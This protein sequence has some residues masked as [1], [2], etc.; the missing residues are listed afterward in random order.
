MNIIKE[1]DSIIESFKTKV[2]P[3]PYIQNGILLHEALTFCAACVSSK[4]DLII[5]SGIAGGR[6]TE[7][8][9]KFFNIPIIGVD[10][11]S[12]YGIER[13]LSTRTRLNKYTNVSIF[14]GDSFNIIPDLLDAYNNKTIAVHIDGPKGENAKILANYCLKQSNVKFVAIHDTCIP[15]WYHKLTEY[16]NVFYSDHPE[17]I[18]KYRHLDT[19]SK[20]P[21]INGGG[22]GIIWN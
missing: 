18:S 16:N 20:D 22:L 14:N 1:A 4:V 13:F 12:I 8:Y 11:A 15:N 6:S 10:N 5:E 21:N 2:L 7:I 19:D 3:F 9:A 17:I